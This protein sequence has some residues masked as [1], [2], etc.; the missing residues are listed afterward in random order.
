MADRNNLPAAMLHARIQN[1][2]SDGGPTLTQFYSFL[3]SFF[4]FFFFFF[5]FL[6]FIR[7][8]EKI[9]L[10]ADHQRPASGRPFK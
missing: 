5:F 8:E 6:R 3:F 7:G 1:V 4:F 10:S 9:Q 2:L